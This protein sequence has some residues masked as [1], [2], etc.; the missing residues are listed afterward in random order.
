MKIFRRFASVRHGSLCFLLFMF[1]LLPFLACGAGSPSA[2]RPLVGGPCEYKKYKGEAEII[3]VTERSGAP[4]EYVIQFMFR[5]QETIAEDFARP[6]GKT[7]RLVPKDLSVPKKDFLAQYGIA[8]GKRLPCYLKAITRGTCT[9]V[10]F[11]FPTLPGGS[12]Q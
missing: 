8:P 6:E 5:P 10:L 2:K 3:S 4:G 1:C 9:P 7:W 11:E 12:A